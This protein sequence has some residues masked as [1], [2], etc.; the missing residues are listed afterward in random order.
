MSKS[1]IVIASICLA[2]FF[3]FGC[4]DKAATSLPGEQQLATNDTSANLIECP[5][6]RPDF[7]TQVYQPVCGLLDSGIRC[8]T[9]PCPSVEQKTFGSACMACGDK[10]VIG[11]LEGECVPEAQELESNYPVEPQ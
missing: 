11:Y 2:C 9:T 8:I 5:E 6:H 1:F 4:R 3:T 10:N 7:C